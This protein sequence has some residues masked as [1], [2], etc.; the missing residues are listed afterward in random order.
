MDVVEHGLHVTVLVRNPKT[1]ELMVNFDESVLLVIREVEVMEK[2]GLDIPVFAIGLKSQE[3]AFKRKSNQL[4]VWM[5][6]T[7]YPF[8]RHILSN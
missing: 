7:L 2:L 3:V 6:V 4:R 8:I 5:I 1:K